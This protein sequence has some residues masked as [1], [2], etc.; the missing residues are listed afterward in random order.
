[1]SCLLKQ[2]EDEII[3]W[4]TLAKKY[5]MFFWFKFWDYFEKNPKNPKKN[6]K[7]VNNNKKIIHKKNPKN[8]KSEI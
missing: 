8:V 5:S 7:N 1:M 4:K 2:F 3:K 6:Y